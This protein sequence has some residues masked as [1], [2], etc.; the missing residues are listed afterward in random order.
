MTCEISITTDIHGDGTVNYI[1]PDPE[2]DRRGVYK[3]GYPVALVNA[4]HNFRGF[5]EGLPYRCAMNVIDGNVNDVEAMIA[6]I[7]SENSLIQ[8]WKRN[9]DWEVI[10]NDLT[11]DGW[12]LRV[13]TTNPGFSN[14]AGLTRE[15]VETFL[16]NWY[17]DVISVHKNEVIF[18]VTIY[19]DGSFNPGALRSRGFWGFTTGLL[20]F[21]EL[22]YNQGTGIHRI[23]VNYGALIPDKKAGEIV[24]EKG[25]EII[26]NVGGVI[27]FDISRQDVLN[28][29]KEDIKGKLRTIIYRRQF[30]IPETAV[31]DII[32]NGTQILINH[33]KG[34]VEYRVLDVTMAQIQSFL[35]NRLNEDL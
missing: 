21:D 24:K 23:E 7:F 13:F 34:Q 28:E 8:K 15:K 2:K 10:N 22:A 27:T 31:D 29:F 6:T 11:I 19:Q 14:I 17:A 30:R 33:P 26:T 16:N 5:K 12:R 20:T 3:K 9:I 1:H 32:S 25:G 4:P 18:D 35:I